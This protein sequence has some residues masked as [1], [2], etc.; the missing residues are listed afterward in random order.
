MKR[1]RSKRAA[2]A[3]LNLLAALLL[4]LA[5]AAAQEEGM[6]EEPVIIRGT[7]QVTNP[8]FLRD[9]A[10]PFVMLED[11]AGFVMRDWEFTFPIESQVIAPIF[12]DLAEN[13][14]FALNLPAR[15]QGTFVD[16]NNDEEKD[17]GVQV[18]VVAYWANTF[19]DPFL[20]RREGFGWS[21]ALSSAIADPENDDEI[22]GGIMIVWAPD[23]AQGFPSGFGDDGLLF[24]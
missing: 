21:N 22:V 24:T 18:F 17:I 8:F 5:P 14:Q 13:P 15:P 16:V 11:E 1:L 23:D 12:G 2:L 19:R 10:E 20:D 9:S 3:A 7:F 4:T 6:G